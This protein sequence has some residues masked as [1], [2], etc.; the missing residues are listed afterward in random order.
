M[1]CKIEG[2]ERNL[3]ARGWCHTH[4]KRWQ[5]HGDPLF[6]LKPRGRKCS[7]D[8]CDNKHA[9]IGYCAKHERHFRRYGRTTT[10]LKRY[11]SFVDAYE[12]QV[13]RNDDG[14]WGWLGAISTAGYSLIFCNGEKKWGH[15]F[16]FEYHEGDIK[17]KNNICHHCD[18]PICTNP[19]HLFQ[20]TMKDNMRDCINKGRFKRAPDESKAKG[21]MVASSKLKEHEVENIKKMIRDGVGNKAIASLYN[22]T[23]KNISSI[24][25]GKTWKHITTNED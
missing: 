2:C 16:S 1:K 17:D 22:V 20:G 15:R 13:I 10:Y 4:Y 12:D 25:V 24:R 18:N 14:C 23:D 5:V 11:E 7:I 6:T 9:S 19:L 8:G 21:S 3:I